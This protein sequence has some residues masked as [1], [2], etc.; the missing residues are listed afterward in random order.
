MRVFVLFA[1]LVLIG[2]AACDTTTST[3]P[4]FGDPYVVNR[5]PAPVLV[6]DTLRAS[7][8]YAGGCEQHSF[9]ARYSLDGTEV[10]LYHDGNGDSC[11][12]Y[13]TQQ[14]EVP[15]DSSRLAPPPLRLYINPA[16][17]IELMIDSLGTA[18]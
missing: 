14:I 9:E 7:V 1:A 2:L 17:T 13:L 18:P 3:I 6:D 10:W 11:E 5:R 4:V 16:E 8:S 12:A 15:L